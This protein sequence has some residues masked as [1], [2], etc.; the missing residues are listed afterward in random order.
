MAKGKTC[1]PPSQGITAPNCT[2]GTYNPINFMVFKPSN[3]MQGYI[4]SIRIDE[5]GLDPGL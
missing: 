5:K 3:W 1:S 2:P 4:V